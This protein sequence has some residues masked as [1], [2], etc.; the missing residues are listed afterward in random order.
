MT[1]TS[2]MY[3]S[4]FTKCL[5]QLFQTQIMPLGGD[6]MEF[7]QNLNRGGYFNTSHFFINNYKDIRCN[8]FTF[9]ASVKH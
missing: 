7:M 2:K 6:S 4:T 8:L 3:A 9:L 1:G 5:D